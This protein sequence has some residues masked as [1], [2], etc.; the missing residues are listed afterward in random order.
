[1]F[2]GWQSLLFESRPRG[3]TRQGECGVR[4]RVPRHRR[5]LELPELPEGRVEVVRR[6]LR[7]FRKMSLRSGIRTVRVGV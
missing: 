7:N 1:M 5:V 4:A 3:N 2:S 6:H